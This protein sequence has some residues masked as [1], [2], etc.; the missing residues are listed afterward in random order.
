[1]S[2]PEVVREVHADADAVAQAAAQALLALLTTRLAEPG[3]AHVVLTG[4]GVADR[5]HR[6]V[7]ALLH[8]GDARARDL[9]WHRVVFWWGDERHVA[10]DSPDRNARQAQEALLHLLPESVQH[11]MPST[12]DE[13]DLDAAAAS[14][15]EVVATRAPT[16]FDLVMLGV[17][18]DAHI[19]SLFPGRAGVGVSD[20]AVIAVPD[21][22]KPPPARVSLTLPRL[23][24]ATEVWLLAAGAEK[25]EAVAAA[26]DDTRAVDDVPAGGVHGRRRTRWFLDAA[27][28][29]TA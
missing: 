11:P 1:M 26:A 22:P 9:P 27:A 13:P 15:A 4:G 7:A 8:D 16:E 25:A 2:A 19:A 17:G 28:A 5:T 18:P 23:C 21:S 6:A 29:G 12:D 20:G 14:Y 24:A 10:A 3:E